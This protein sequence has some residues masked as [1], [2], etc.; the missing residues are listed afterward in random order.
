MAMQ[1]DD[2]LFMSHYCNCRTEVA[3]GAADFSYFFSRFF[4][5][6]DMGGNKRMCCHSLEIS[7]LKWDLLYYGTLSPMPACF[8]GLHLRRARIRRHLDSNSSGSCLPGS[9]IRARSLIKCSRLPSTSRRQWRTMAASGPMCRRQREDGN[10]FLN[11]LHRFKRGKV[12]RIM[13]FPQTNWLSIIQAGIEDDWR[14]GE[15][16]GRGVGWG[17][18]VIC[19]CSA[20]RFCVIGPGLCALMS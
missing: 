20:W 7:P 15:E 8:G 4:P 1:S 14:H 6:A 11:L 17:G 16:T 3:S 13:N 12:N 18:P 10:K 9:E 5:P 2:F 19:M